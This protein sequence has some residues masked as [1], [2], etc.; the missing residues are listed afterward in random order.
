MISPP[1]VFMFLCG[2]LS[3]QGQLAE[4]GHGRH[5]SETSKAKSQETQTCSFPLFWV[6]CPGK[7]QLA[8]K[9]LGTQAA[10]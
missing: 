6:A 9:F 1:L 5:D 8:D 4:T 10:W 2:L 3:Q 7:S